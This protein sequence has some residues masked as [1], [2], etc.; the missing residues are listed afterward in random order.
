MSYPYHLNFNK[1]ILEFVSIILLILFTGYSLISL[2]RPEEN[3]INI[4]KKPI[5]TSRV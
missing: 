1:S 2:L 4:L 3:Y 5:T